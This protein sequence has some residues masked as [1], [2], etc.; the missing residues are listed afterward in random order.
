ME[1]GVGPPM[2]RTDP[3]RAAACYLYREGQAVAGADL[4]SVLVR[5]DAEPAGRPLALADGPL[6]PRA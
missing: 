5:G 1:S 4:G 2:F 6:T 3:H